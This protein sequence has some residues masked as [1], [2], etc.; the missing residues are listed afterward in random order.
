M[1]WIVTRWL[2]V[3]GSRQVQRETWDLTVDT[4]RV[5]NGVARTSSWSN[6]SR[7]HSE[8]GRRMVRVITRRGTVALVYE[9][10][11]KHAI[12]RI[13]KGII[14]WA[15]SSS[16]RIWGS[17]GVHDGWLLLRLESRGLCQIKGC[18]VLGQTMVVIMMLLVVVSTDITS[19]VPAK[20]VDLW[21]CV[22]VCCEKRKATIF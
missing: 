7:T 3:R 19:F 17:R 9:W 10:C 16:H 1:E 6:R 2:W 11:L 20:L 4:E 15:H 8:I 18:F 5:S 14:V 12:F 13:M 21:V 22:C